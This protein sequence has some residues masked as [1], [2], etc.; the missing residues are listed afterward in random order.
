MCQTRKQEEE[1]IRYK[2][3]SSFHCVISR[4]IGPSFNTYI[5]Y[6]YTVYMR[7]LICAW[8]C[9]CCVASFPYGTFIGLSGIF[10]CNCV[11]RLRMEASV[12][13]NEIPWLYVTSPISHEK[14][15]KSNKAYEK[16]T[17]RYVY[18]NETMEHDPTPATATLT[19]YMYRSDRSNGTIE[20]RQKEK[21]E[22]YCNMYGACWASGM[23]GAGA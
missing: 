8:W 10:C 21:E 6:V 11:I 9:W 18:R 19:L 7:C 14:K 3:L 4:S 2:P 20:R 17:A 22:Y 1:I 16:H 23:K 5:Y 13:L 15:K 12:L